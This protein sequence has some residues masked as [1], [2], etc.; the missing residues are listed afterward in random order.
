MADGRRIWEFKNLPSGHVIRGE[1]VAYWEVESDP[2]S[3]DYTPWSAA[4]GRSAFPLTRFHLTDS[5][6]TRGTL[7]SVATR[8]W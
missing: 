4:A 6:G 8:S 1:L 2:V 5:N 7:G 3:D